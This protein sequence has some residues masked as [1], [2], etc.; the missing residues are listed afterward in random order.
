MVVVVLGIESRCRSFEDS[1][2]GKG[3]E[4]RDFVELDGCDF[5][6]SKAGHHTMNEDDNR[7]T[8]T[9][10]KLRRIVTTDGRLLSTSSGSDGEGD[11]RNSPSN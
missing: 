7:G 2:R 4:V 8:I 3:Y 6:R 1:P 10:R 9:R 11:R 5:C